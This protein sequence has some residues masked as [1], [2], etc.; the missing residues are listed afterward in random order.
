MRTKGAVATCVALALLASGCNPNDRAFFR[1]GIGTELYTADAIPAT[2]L[3]N[4]YLDQ[5]CRQSLPFVGPDVPSCSQQEL[6]PTAWS[7][8]VQAGM[9]DIDA[10]CDSYLAWL[11][12]KKR[13]NSAVLAEIGAIRFAVDALTN[14]AVATGISPVALAAVSAAFGLAT[15]TLAN[16]NTLLIQVDHTTVQSIV[17]INRRDFREGVL[18][19]AVTNK[20]SA[21]HALRSYLEIC[22][23]MTISANINS[24]VTVFQQTGPGI[25]GKRPLVAPPSIAAPFVPREP[26]RDRRPA[27]GSTVSLVPGADLII[28]GYPQNARTYT[29]E[30]IATILGALCA[31]PTELKRIGPVTKALLEIWEVTD[32]QNGTPNGSIDDRERKA[33]LAL[34]PCPTG[35]LNAFERQTFMSAANVGLLVTLLNRVPIEGQLGSASLPDARPRVALVRRNCF[36]GRLNPLPNGMNVQVTSDLMSALREYDRMRKAAEAQAPPAPPPPC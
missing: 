9:N 3:Q 4:I 2:D 1:E 10:R 13:E 29:P 30:V 28:P 15:N 34:T 25:L 21:V 33:L 7:L 20:P 8:I 26:F 32:T 16:I 6:P 11:D 35:V 22:M 31:P 17:F 14:P 18:R 12:Q 24:T 5:L 36:A 19:L 23:P 27:E